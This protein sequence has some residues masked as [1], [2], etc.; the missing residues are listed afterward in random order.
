[1]LFVNSDECGL[2]LWWWLISERRRSSISASYCFKPFCLQN[3]IA[4]RRSFHL[5]SLVSSNFE[6]NLYKFLSELESSS[7][8]VTCLLLSTLESCLPRVWRCI[9]G[10]DIFL[11]E[12]LWQGLFH[13]NFRLVFAQFF[14]RLLLVVNCFQHSNTLFFGIVRLLCCLL[15]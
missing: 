8:G 9:F 2:D 10:E 13:A 12:R 15:F 4:R 14:K 5:S 11:A 3:T 1:M 6:F 7:S